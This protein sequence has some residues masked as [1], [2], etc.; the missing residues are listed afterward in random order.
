MSMFD[1][2]E[3]MIIPLSIDDIDASRTSYFFSTKKLVIAFVAIVPYVVL[4]IFIFSALPSIPIALAF[5][6]LYLILYLWII[7][8]FVIEE[9]VQRDSLHELQDNKFSDPAYFWEIDKTGDNK[10]K[11]DGL[12]YL[13][14]DGI[15]LKRGLVVKFD[16]GSIVGTPDDFLHNY[17]ETQQL[18]LRSLYQNKLNF[19]W[20]KIQKQP[21]LNKSLIKQSEQLAE[22]DND[23]LR[24]LLKL[25]LNA[26]L[27]VSMDAD[28]RYV[29]YIV[30]TNKDFATLTN[31]KT[32]LEDVVNNTL[33]TNPAFKDV[34]ILNKAGVDDFFS[35]YYMQD[36]F[37]TNAISKSNRSKPFSSYAK[38]IQIVDR[39]NEVVDIALVDALNEQLERDAT[40]YNLDEVF[41][42]EE[43][44][45][46][47]LNKRR[48]SEKEQAIKNLRKQRIDDKITHQE[49]LE[50]AAE[51]EE[52]YSP[53]NY[54][55]NRAEDEKNALKE[56]RRLER[57]AARNEKRA[58]EPEA[59]E[60]PKWFENEDFDLD[61]DSDVMETEHIFEDEHE[62]DYDLD[63][64]LNKE[65]PEVSD[66]D[67]DED[68]VLFTEESL[69]TKEVQ[70]P[71]ISE[72][73][74]K[75]SEEITEHEDIDEDSSQLYGNLFDE[76]NDEDTK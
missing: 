55:P 9:S 4:I 5:T 12:L 39:D 31:F 32:V 75:V 69:E 8:T 72:E 15:T 47:K 66:E 70:E 43:R 24:K 23:A 54:N 63:F 33:R 53:E 22:C 64:I 45:E 36:D 48:E 3:K 14:Q 76:D 2:E 16:S 40:G 52:I 51:V 7:R 62:V 30:V 17:R 57:I 6:A 58:K 56:Q 61:T 60:E 38:V 11:D 1:D 20:Y 13:R 42:A 41:S 44:K 35:N 26:Y 46:A 65:I 67:S 25:Q 74:T 27:R 50:K 10:D 59:V 28:Q 18:F 34:E 29:D 68:D 73:I 71:V 19:K 49:Y 37:D 21:E